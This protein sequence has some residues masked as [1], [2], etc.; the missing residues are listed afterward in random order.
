MDPLSPH[1]RATGS[2][3]A[4]HFGRDAFVAEHDVVPTGPPDASGM[5]PIAVLAG[6]STHVAANG[7]ELYS[8]YAG[9]G[10]VDLATGRIEFELEGQYTGGTGRF[11]NATGAT[12]IQGVVESGVATYSRGR[13]DHVLRLG[14]GPAGRPPARSARR[15]DPVPQ[16]LH[17]LRRAA[18][19]G[20]PP[21]SPP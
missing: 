11:A 4:T 17:R 7:D 15:V 8:A 9:T 5:L 1:V 2:C 10:Q 18:P 14:R 16:Q 20:S 12:R 6:R 13:L 21:A 3:Q 19:C